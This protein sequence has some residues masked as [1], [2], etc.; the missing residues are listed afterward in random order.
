MGFF[1]SKSSSTTN[2]R[3]DQNTEQVG[4]GDIGGGAI[5][6]TGGSAI[7]INQDV[8]FD[9][10]FTFGEAAFDFAQGLGDSAFDAVT[11]ISEQSREV[12]ETMAGAVADGATFKFEPWHLLA[13]GAGLLVLFKIFKGN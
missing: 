9:E 11:Q 3:V 10:A 5:I 1:D 4:G 13:G 12:Q 2:N 6:G 7:T 8:G